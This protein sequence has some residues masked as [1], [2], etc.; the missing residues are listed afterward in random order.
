MMG[1]PGVIGRYRARGPY[2]DAIRA[3]RAVTDGLKD[4]NPDCQDQQRQ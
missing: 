4:P 3:T 1:T 2:T